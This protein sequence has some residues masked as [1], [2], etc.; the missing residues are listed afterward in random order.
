MESKKEET[1]SK[2]AVPLSTK[3]KVTSKETSNVNKKRKAPKT[4]QGVENLKKVNTSS[5]AK[6]SSFFN[7]KP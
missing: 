5:M 4:S 2:A 3:A 6:I 7:K 1:M